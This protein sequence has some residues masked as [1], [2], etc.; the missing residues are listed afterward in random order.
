M[1]STG[2]DWTFARLM[3]LYMMSPREVRRI[4]AEKHKAMIATIRAFNQVTTGRQV[5]SNRLQILILE[6]ANAED[7]HRDAQIVLAMLEHREFR[8]ALGVV[9]TLWGRLRMART[10][11]RD[12]QFED[13]LARESLD[14]HTDLRQA[15]TEL[16]VIAATIIAN[17]LTKTALTL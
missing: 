7:E 5:D 16:T 12:D 15:W 17:P 3:K 6:K 1:L 2:S 8:H 11:L 10:G 14:S 9:Y 4:H 13:M